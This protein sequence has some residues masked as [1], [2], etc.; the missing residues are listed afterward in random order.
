M[1]IL[2]PPFQPFTFNRFFCSVISTIALFSLP[3]AHAH[4]DSHIIGHSY[5][6]ANY[7]V[8]EASKM[9]PAPSKGMTQHIIYLPKKNNEAN[10][11]IEFEIGQTK[12]IDCNKHSLTGKIDQHSVKGWG[13]NYYQVNS[14]APGPST[15]RA[16]MKFDKKE[17]F[18]RLPSDLTLHYNSRVPFVFY[19][20][21]KAQLRYR[22]WEAQSPFQ[23]T[24]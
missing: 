11:K 1:K 6:S 4:A 2:T 16:C 23:T 14:I 8:E 21:E 24:E 15:M 5:T 20:P 18:I 7:Q 3:Y 9:F 12:V 22:I 19:L 13:Y 10:Y 17:A